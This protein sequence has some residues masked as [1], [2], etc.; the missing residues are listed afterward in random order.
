MKKCGG[1]GN[2]GVLRGICNLFLQKRLRQKILNRTTDGRPY[3]THRA[4]D[5]P[6]ERK[7]PEEERSALSSSGCFHTV[8]PEFRFRGTS[9]PDASG[10]SGSW[11]FAL[12]PETRRRL[13][14]VLGTGSHQPPA[15]CALGHAYSSASLSSYAIV[16][17]VSRHSN[18]RNLHARILMRAYQSLAQRANITLGEAKHITFLRKKKHIPPRPLPRPPRRPRRR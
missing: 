1:R 15:L 9:S 14:R 13:P 16:M 7:H 5:L 18:E 6:K 11:D 17:I 3:G 2:T 4:A 12:F 8:P 10:A